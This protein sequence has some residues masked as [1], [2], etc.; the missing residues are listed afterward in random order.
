MIGRDRL[1]RAAFYIAVSLSASL[2]IA[3]APVVKLLYGHA[4]WVFV[5][6]FAAGVPLGLA[7]QKRRVSTSVGRT[8]FG[9]AYALLGL[10]I[11][12]NSHSGFVPGASYWVRVGFFT[13]TLVAWSWIGRTLY[14]MFVAPET[15]EERARP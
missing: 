4:F 10:A 3:S 12:G 2:V 6:A 9:V 5:I 15:A 13:L 14:G 7:A 11:Q 1:V 8:G